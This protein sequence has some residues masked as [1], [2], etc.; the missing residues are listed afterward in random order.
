M[1]YINIGLI[2]IFAGVQHKFDIG[3]TLLND[4]TYKQAPNNVTDH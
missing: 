1:A 4:L 3:K 2:A